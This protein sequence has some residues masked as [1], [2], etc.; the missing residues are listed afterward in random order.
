MPKKSTRVWTTLGI[1]SLAGLV[2]CSST[3]SQTHTVT[4][5]EAAPQAQLR[6]T[7]AQVASE[8]VAGPVNESLEDYRKQRTA[9][10][11]QGLRFEDGLVAIDTQAALTLQRS[12]GAMTSAE[13]FAAVANLRMQNNFS[14]ALSA[15]RWA[16]LDAPDN[17]KAYEGLGDALIAKR[18]DGMALAAY[19]S[20]TA[21][22]PE[23]IESRMKLAETINRTGDLAGWA[24]ELANVLALD[25]SNGEAHARMAVAKHYL[26]DDN[27]AREQIALAE[28]LGGHVPGA[29]K[30]M[31]T[32]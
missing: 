8:P 26:G 27:A 17:A 1:V 3:Q 15:Y 16:I 7:Q 24:D 31:L 5:A 22:D 28:K 18:K 29:L 11:L 21:L 32:K 19:R 13:A 6:N 30:A 12:A 2:G 20:A 9:K 23:N 14:G 4:G 25:P 10:A